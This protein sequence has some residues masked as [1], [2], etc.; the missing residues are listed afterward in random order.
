MI[1]K[2]LVLIKPDGVQRGLIGEIILRFEKC[3]LKIIGIKMVYA[4]RELAGKHY[5]D[6]EAWLKSVGEKSI[7]SYENQGK[8]LTVDPLTQGKQV[9]EWLLDY[10]TASPIV[11][12]IL[13]GHNAV[14]NVRKIVGPTS[15]ADAAPGTI[16]GDFTF[17]TPMLGD[18]QKRPVQ[19]LI[20]ASGSV[21]EAQTEIKIWFKPEE[22]HAWKRID[23]DLL[24]REGN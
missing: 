24:Y 5:T 11:A 18:M 3:G 15:P 14:R 16:R 10:I 8:K 12:L 2:T 17:D 20:H 4:S 13:E 19:N 7:K 23:E 22:I 1:E 21:E 6:D 9:R